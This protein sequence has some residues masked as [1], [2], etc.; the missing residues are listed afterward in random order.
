MRSLLLGSA[1]AL[2]MNNADSCDPPG[3]GHHDDD[4]E[5]VPCQ[6]PPGLY[7]DGSCTE[8]AEGVYPYEPLYALWSDGAEKDRFIYLPPGTQIDTTNPD[9]WNFPQGTRIYKTFSRDGVR[10]ETRL[11]TKTGTAANIASWTLVAYQWS[12]DQRSVTLAP[13]A[14]V[15]NA[16]GTTHDIPSQAQCRS[17]HTMTNLDA[18]NGFGAIQ[19]NHHDWRG[20]VTLHSLLREDLLVNAGGTEPN[21]TLGNSRIHG[22]RAAREGMGYLHAN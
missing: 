19:L 11:I 20:G 22:S 5:D 14:G 17:C 21:I 10:I 3:H 16:L 1:L 12:A 2:F 6:G 13:S 18:P 9:R 15:Q 4:E 8:L 7:V